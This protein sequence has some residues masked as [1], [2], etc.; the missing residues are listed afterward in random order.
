MTFLLSDSITRPVKGEKSR[1]ISVN[2]EVPAAYD[3][4]ARE[5]NS[6]RHRINGIVLFIRSDYS[7]KTERVQD[8]R[9][10]FMGHD[11]RYEYGSNTK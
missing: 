4:L 10:R 5:K 11:I 9:A 8:L 6:S 1:S 2:R 7:R 3:P